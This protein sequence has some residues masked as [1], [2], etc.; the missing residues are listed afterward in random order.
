VSRVW[1]EMTWPREV[2]PEQALAGLLA[3]AGLATPRRRDAVVLQA[4][5]EGGQVRHHVA[6]QP[7]RADVVRRQLET[8]LPGLRC[9]RLDSNPA[10][11]ITAAW[12]M[13]LTNRR[14]PLQQQESQAVS[15][16][17]ITALGSAAADELVMIQWILGPSR[18]PLVVGS[19]VQGEHGATPIGSPLLAPV[20]RPGTL[21]AEHR[22][23]LRNKQG[24]P[25]WRAS[26]RIG[27]RANGRARQLELFGRIT[28][29]LR[30]AQAP[31]V[32]PVFFPTSTH[33]LHQ[34]RLPLWWPVPLNVAE[35]RTLVGWPIGDTD[36]LPVQHVPSRHLAVPLSVARRG[37]VVAVAG[38][39]ERA[40][41]IALSPA[42]SLHHL[43]LIGPTGVGKSTVLLNLIVQDLEAGRGVIV[44]EPKGDLIADVLARIPDHRLDHVVV[45]DPTDSAPVGV[46]PLAGP[47]SPE[48]KVDSLLAMFKGL[49]GD[50]IGPRTQDLLT[51]GLLTLVSVPGMT[52]VHLPL[53][54]T[55]SRFRSRIRQTARDPLALDPF[56]SWFDALSMAEQGAVL[57]PVMN[58]LRQFLLR[59]QVRR[60]IGQAAPRFDLRQVFTERRVLLVNLAKG[61]TGTEAAS[62]LGSLIVSH[63]WQATL[64]RQRVAPERRHPVTWVID[65]FQDYLRLPT[66]LA[67]VLSQAR[68]MG[69]GVHLA[70]QHLAQ[71][72]PSMKAAV[73]ANARS[74]VVFQTTVDDARALIGSD[75]RLTPADVEGLGKYEAYV[76][77]MANGERTP[78]ASACTMP[79]APARR[80]PNE[81]RRHSR[82][83][84]GI[85]VTDIEAALAQ[86]HQ[87]QPRNQPNFGVVRRPKGG[88]S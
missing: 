39:G 66:D 63:I 17:I 82:D 7:H 38:R 52:L 31:G 61:S 12:R 32:R 18:S 6:V 37:R 21:D 60:V 55:D 25:G 35:A 49:F 10:L 47:G 46:N 79:P 1:F 62:L 88:D 59:P 44:I 74:R 67:D 48:V 73:L 20:A 43:H 57:A 40:R 78:Y 83:R 50:A 2:K 54:F 13:G 72:P 70:H 45:I 14:R 15:R 71:M 51:A 65:E 11:R 19:D 36:Q 69:V 24:M 41:A 53:L 85:P 3:L 58:K 77:L 29:A 75:K 23:L 64:A 30:M 33:H 5:G 68:A 4:V 86:L 34:E 16:A 27:V 42:D 26:L 87:D 8:A 22:K 56:W 81:P 84:W 28:A 80:D 9:Q 76:S